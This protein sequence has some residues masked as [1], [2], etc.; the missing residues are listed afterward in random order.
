MCV[1]LAG[2]ICVARK[3]AKG[4]EGGKLFGA[5]TPKQVKAELLKAIDEE[6]LRRK[7]TKFELVDVKGDIKNVG[8]YGCRVLFSEDTE[9]TFT[10]KVTGSDEECD[11]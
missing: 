7:S 10:I 8:E 1:A 5:V 4:D 3:T 11:I 2:T 9:A 6:V